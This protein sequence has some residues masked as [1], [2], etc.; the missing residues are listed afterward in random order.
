MKATVHTWRRLYETAAEEPDWVRAH[1]WGYS[2]EVASRTIADIREKLLLDSQ[3]RLLEVGCGCGMVL[4][5]LLQ[6]NQTGVGI[7]FS[8]SLL[9][10]A[11]AFGV[12]LHNIELIAGEAARPP[13]ADDTFDRVFCY[14]VFQCLP[15]PQ[16]AVRS[17]RELIRV[18]KPGGVILVGDVFGC[19]ERFRT[20]WQDGG[21]SIETAR[22]A[23]A[24]PWLLPLRW[25]LAPLRWSFA[26]RHRIGG[27]R[28]G[29]DDDSLPR[30]HYS[31]HF[32]RRIGHECGCEVEILPQEIPGREISR[33]RFDV[34]LMKV[35]PMNRS[36]EQYG[37]C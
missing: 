8:H 26:L 37:L 17:L 15:T 2:Q 35:E 36:G 22:A 30:R 24:L 10:K 29:D 31:H 7:D 16:Y 9:A 20:A 14:S 28:I 5:T 18:C 19:V 25:A 13:V 23:L 11:R 32:F 33:Q 4:S 12:R 3:H 21:P 27:E 1:R 6:D 34:R